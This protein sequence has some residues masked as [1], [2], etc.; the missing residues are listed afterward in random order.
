M[1]QTARHEHGVP[2]LD[3]FRSWL[4]SHSFLPK[5]PLGQAATYTLNQWDAPCR[6]L[7][8][9]ELAFDNNR[10]ERAM[11]P[12]AI[13]QKNWLFVGSSLAGERAAILFA[14][15]A[16]RKENLFESWAY[17]RDA[18]TR[19]PQGLSDE[20]LLEL[21]PDR[22]LQAQ[23]EHRWS[24]AE[25]RREKLIANSQG[26]TSPTAYEVLERRTSAR[27]PSRLLTPSPTQTSMAHIRSPS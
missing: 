26:C 21:L 25:V 7:D 24:I 8:D 27:T 20:Q 4:D 3:Q 19:L 15:L 1:R 13:S 9:G 11:R 5:T 6:Y 14:R 23:P 12:L 2:L 16:S 17:L 18:F 10:A 22:W